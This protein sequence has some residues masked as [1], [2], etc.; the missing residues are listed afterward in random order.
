MSTDLPLDLTVRLRA[1]GDEL[2]RAVEPVTAGEARARARRDVTASS[3]AVGDVRRHAVVT[4]VTRPRP[5]RTLLGVAAACVVVVGIAGVFVAVD[6][7]DGEPV[8]TQVRPPATTAAAD[9]DGGPTDPPGEGAA[10]VIDAT[11][12]P[13]PT[14][15]V[16]ADV[17]PALPAGDARNDGAHGGYMQVATDGSRSTSALIAVPDGDRL[18]GG[19]QVVAIDNVAGEPLAP[20]AGR[21]AT[22][23]GAAVTVH[24]GGG[25]PAT[26]TVVVRGDPTIT[27]RG[28]DPVGFLE[29]S[30]LGVATSPAVNASDGSLML[31]IDEASLPPGYEVVVA[32]HP[33][34]LGARVASM[35]IGQGD[36]RAEVGVVDPVVSWA[37]AGDLERVDINGVDGWI[38]TTPGYVVI[39]KVSD[40][41]WATVG[42]NP[43]REDSLQFARELTFVDEA[44]WRQRYAVPEP[45]FEEA[46]DVVTIDRGRDD[47]VSVGL[48]VVGG[49]RLVGTITSVTDAQSTVLL[50]NDARFTAAATLQPG[51]FDD[52]CVA[53]GRTDHI[54]FTCAA[55]F[56]ADVRVGAEIVTSGGGESRFPPGLAIGTI[57]ELLVDGDGE[58]VAI[59]HPLPDPPV[60]GDVLELPR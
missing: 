6:R 15:A 28:L 51:G 38:T 30:G 4:D 47:G 36:D 33:L 16:R 34:P 57:A 10:S 44:T 56:G 25:D 35:S 20:G 22:I 32:P 42:G 55:P 18:T 49:G 48:P 17:Y 5:R 21:S 24:N 29:V 3:P 41:T 7:S 14:S 13:N 43:T 50:S 46:A 54:A 40:T 23:D 52:D 26:T 19:V 2:D 11:V 12:I 8:S 58:E 9:D 59:V 31:T 27:F 37:A 45:L 53:R 60:A 1:V 39:W